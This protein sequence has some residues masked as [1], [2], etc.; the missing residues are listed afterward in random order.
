[1]EIKELYEIYK[2]HPV[3]TT[4]SRNC[5]EGSIFFALKGETFDGNKFAVS[6]IEKGCAY[7][8]VDDPQ[9]SPCFRGTSEAE[10]V[11]NSSLL[12]PHSSL[13][14]VDNVLDTL[15]QLAR[16]H[17]E[18]LGIPVVGITGTNGKTTTKE[19]V[20]TVLSKKYRVHYTQGN[21]NN[22][23]GV[24]LTLLS[25]KPDC[26][27]AV[28][29]MGANHPGEI[30]TLA[31]IALPTCGLITNVGKAHLEGFGSLEGVINTKKEL[32]DNLAEH[33]GHVF[34]N[35]N[36]ELLLNALRKSHSSLLTPHSS[37]ISTYS[38]NPDVAADVNGR[39]LRCAP[40]VEFE[41]HFFDKGS[42]T[43]G[44]QLS[45]LNSQLSTNFVGA[46][47]LD[48]ML[49]AITVGLHFGVDEKDVCDAIS[50]YVPANNRS[51]LTKTERNTLIVDA[52]NAN[53]TSMMAAIDN[54]ELME[55]ENKMAILGDM[56][57]LGEQSEVE[58]QNI[59]RR[60]MESKI[61]KIILVGKEFKAAYS[62]DAINC[63]SADKDICVFDSQ[64]SLLETQCIASL[65]SQLIL[66]KG[67]NG[68]G[69]YK[70]IPYL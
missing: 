27:I 58:H 13:I 52:Y 38:S 1:M 36:N 23:I 65:Q 50:N 5:P 47:N 69:L 46:Y 15:Q 66:L 62:R 26:E 16:Y 51:Q 22:H 53:P 30:K 33:G 29:E 12:T 35:A 44:S 39:L 55:G 48:N 63:V 31:N 40:Y 4:D 21:F 57:E 37:L 60:L 49:A 64:A 59:V 6:A 67:S 11:N 17:R 61:E 10:G 56:L 70:L 28:V 45:T 24:P 20:A 41:W 34:V 2:A 3:V 9:L 43:F 19:L 54:F 25:I 42:K 32:Y 68:I 14:V 8:V 7:A 18:Q